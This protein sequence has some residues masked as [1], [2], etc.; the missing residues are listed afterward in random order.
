MRHIPSCLVAASLFVNKLMG[1]EKGQSI[2][3]RYYLLKKQG[4]WYGKVLVLVCDKMFW[5]DKEH[6]RKAYLLR[7]KEVYDLH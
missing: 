6:C 1:G 5:W 7:K 2:C 4:K 3:A